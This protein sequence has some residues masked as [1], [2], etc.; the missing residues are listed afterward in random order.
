MLDTKQK[1]NLNE[2]QCI[3]AFYEL[4]YSVSIPYGDCDRYDFI[5]DINNKLYR[6]QAK[7]S[8][9]IDE[10]GTIAFSCRSSRSNANGC[11]NRQYT[12]DEIDFFATYWQGKCYLVP[13]E[14]CSSEKKL[15]FTTPLN[16]QKVG[17]SYAK[18]YELCSQISKLLER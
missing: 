5:V 4:G 8:R 17:I 9:L 6:V 13:V 10:N 16:G 7:S 14:E 11:Y 15:R 18:D 3:T 12:A 1:G 2:L